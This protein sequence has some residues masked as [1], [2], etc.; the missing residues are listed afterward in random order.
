MMKEAGAVKPLFLSFNIGY[1]P[2]PV[3]GINNIHN[4]FTM[5]NGIDNTVAANPEP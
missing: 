2:A 3:P 4:Q 1:K 5:V